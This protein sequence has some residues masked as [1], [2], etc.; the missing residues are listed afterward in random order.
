MAPKEKK[1]DRYLTVSRMAE[2]LGCS[3]RHVYEM[4]KEGRL[5]ALRAGDPG[6]FE[7]RKSHSMNL[8]NQTL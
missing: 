4:V 1:Q 7:Y 8:L 2:I 5:K 3:D 6:L